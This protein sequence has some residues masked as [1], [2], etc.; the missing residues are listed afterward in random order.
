MP[1][2][3]LINYDVLKHNYKSCIF[4]RSYFIIKGLCEMEDQEKANSNCSRICIDMVGKNF[5]GGACNT[6]S[7]RCDCM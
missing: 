3:N 2:T 7:H 5:I 4:K 6:T 1:L